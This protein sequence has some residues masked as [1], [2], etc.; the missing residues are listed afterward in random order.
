M[1]DDLITQREKI[2]EEPF[3]PQRSAIVDRID[4]LI[5]EEEADEIPR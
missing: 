5:D 2:L 3:T 1:K 4:Q